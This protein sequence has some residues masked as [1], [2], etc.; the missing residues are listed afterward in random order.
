MQKTSKRKRNKSAQKR[1]NARF[2]IT[3]FLV[4]A[5]AFSL[6]LTPLFDLKYIEI[7]GTSHIP[8][9]DIINTSGFVIG[10]NLF[11]QD[12]KR[13][14]AEISQIPYVESVKIVRYI[15]SAIKIYIKEGQVNMYI[16]FLE[17]LLG[18]NENFKILDVV[19]F[20]EREQKPIVLGIT[21]TEFVIGEKIIIDEQAK[22]DIIK[23]YEQALKKY[24]LYDNT[25]YLDITD[26]ENVK[27][28]YNEKLNVEF[29]KSG[30]IDLVDY[31]VRYVKKLI[32]DGHIDTTK[33]GV[34]T[35]TG[36]DGENS[37]SVTYKPS[38]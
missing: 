37:G 19:A 18:V 34:L 15:P 14:E 9:E 29:G 28:V 22:Y 16:P 32:D 38:Q 25:T 23:L 36:L 4:I 3:L 5:S 30:N 20:E 13:A 1:R 11:K 7:Y 12:I 8:N 27:I 2:L 35:L 26:T 24:D 33:S 17:K 31:K 10:E 21:T 6:V